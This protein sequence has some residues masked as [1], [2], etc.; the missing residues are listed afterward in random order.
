MKVFLPATFVW[1]A[2]EFLSVLIVMG[3]AVI[4]CYIRVDTPSKRLSMNKNIEGFFIEI[5]LRK[6]RKWLVS[7]SYNP[8][9]M[10]YEK[11]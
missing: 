8:T 3:M 1:M 2:T 11:H 9:K 5:K 6:K 4:F 10:Q 7:C